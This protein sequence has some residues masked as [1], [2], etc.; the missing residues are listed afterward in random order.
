MNNTLY[1][2]SCGQDQSGAEAEKTDFNCPQCGGKLLPKE[3]G[4]PPGNKTGVRIAAF[5]AMA[6]V[7]FA[8]LYFLRPG[9]E[10]RSPDIPFPDNS[11]SGIAASLLESARSLNSKTPFMVD[12]STRL[13]EVVV[14]GSTITYKNTLV[15]LTDEDRAREDVFKKNITRYLTEKYCGNEKA[16]N[17]MKAGIVY[18]QDY[19]GR[20][21][22]LLFSATVT[23]ADCE[24]L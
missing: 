1:C 18:S 8:A 21:G 20:D 10:Y 9:K 4:T 12:N 14:E 6:V 22:A 5:T 17:G 3:Q 13:D 15:N 19:S 11:G 7:A 23:Y 24:A 2:K 16:R